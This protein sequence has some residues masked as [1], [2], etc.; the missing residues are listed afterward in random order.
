M[1]LTAYFRNIIWALPLY[2]V[3]PIPF[4]FLAQEMGF[5]LNLNV[6]LLGALGWWI[7][8]I[9][10][11]PVI[12]IVKK[13]GLSNHWVVGASGPAEELTRYIILVLIGL[14]SSN[15]FSIGLGWASIEVIYGLVNIIGLGVLE[16]KT[17]EKALEAKTIM[18]QMGMDKV[19]NSSTPFWGALERLS[20]NAF[21][22]GF[23][24]LLLFHPLVLIITIP[25]HSLINFYVVRMNKISIVKSQI[26]LL[27]IGAI[28][29][30]MGYLLTSN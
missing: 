22:I 8:L 16:Q 1:K 9:V 18:K 5:D 13:K 6:F 23:S 24:L 25:L 11:V 15:A 21:H 12:L 28:V 2:L 20:A 7:A 14:S 30:I 26:G 10:R 3:S 17:D 27:F 19:M 4:Y 29:F